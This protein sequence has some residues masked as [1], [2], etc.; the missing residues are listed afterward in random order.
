MI[1]CFGRG[2]VGPL[3]ALALAAGLPTHAQEP[4]HLAVDR[5]ARAVSFP[6]VVQA[7]AFLA[8]LPPDHQYHAVVHEDGSAA[9]K[10]LFVTPVPDAAIARALRE[11][12][13]EDGGGVPLAAWSLRWVPLVPQPDS[14]VAGT[15]V[16]VR[17]EWSGA[18]RVYDL[19]ELVRDPGGRGIEM[20]FG[21]NEEHDDE[22]HSGCVVCFF[23]CPGG[24]ISNAAYTIR[25][26][27]RVVTTFDPGDR[28]PPDGTPVTIS[29]RL[30]PD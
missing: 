8:S 26:H 15:R 10:A 17:V 5:E 16:E 6:A 11:M 4:G 2:R 21:G 23:S 9:D 25:D 18:P 19:V 3:L 22:W 7:D 14:R 24:V 1:A 30:V 28:L 20:R 29:L 27:Q 13:A 12:G